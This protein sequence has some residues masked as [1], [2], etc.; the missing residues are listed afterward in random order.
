MEMPMDLVVP[1][2]AAS[3]KLVGIAVLLRSKTVRLVSCV[4]RFPVRGSGVVGAN[5]TSAHR[6]IQIS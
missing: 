2:Q 5:E 6:R 3:V 4:V 1:F